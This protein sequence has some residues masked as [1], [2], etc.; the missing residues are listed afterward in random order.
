MSRRRIISNADY[1][2]S[3]ERRMHQD[4]DQ[5]IV[6]I[7]HHAI[8]V[9]KAD[10]ERM[11]NFKVGRSDLEN[12]KTSCCM[13]S[14]SSMRKDSKTDSWSSNKYPRKDSMWTNEKQIQKYRSKSQSGLVMEERKKN[15]KT[16]IKST[17]LPNYVKLRRKIGSTELPMQNADEQRKTS[18]NGTLTK[19]SKERSNYVRKTTATRVSTH[20][21]A[22]S[23]V[24]STHSNSPDM[25]LSIFG[26]CTGKRKAQAS[27]VARNSSSWNLKTVRD[28]L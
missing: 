6:K 27:S 10:I 25:P 15:S 11:R 3:L 16:A 12:T 7:K 28:Y 21:R 20:V 18:N 5:D 14:I 23:D 1:M 2:D 24:N 22:F 26:F 19:Q 9:S 17:T 13:D 8:L 4:R